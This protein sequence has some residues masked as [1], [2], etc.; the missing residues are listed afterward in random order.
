LAERTLPGGGII[1]DQR[2]D[3]DKIVTRGF[4]VATDRFMSGWGP[5][6][7]GKSLFAVPFR[8]YAEARIVMDNMRG[9]SEM[10]KAREVGRDYKPQLGPHDHLSIRSI[11]DASRFY[12]KGS[13]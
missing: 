1:D 6:R 9:R 13:W 12:E 2:S 5:C 10:C 3:Q 7:G 11:E 4:I 8:N